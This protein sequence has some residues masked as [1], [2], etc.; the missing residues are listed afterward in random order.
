MARYFLRFRHSDTGLT[1]TYNFFKKASDLSVVTP[2]A[3]GEVG[4]GTYY[5]DYSPTFDIVF[6]VDGGVSIP[7]EE[8]RYIADT[9]SPKDVFVDEPTSQVKDDVWNDVVN[10]T[11]GTKG[12]YVEKI[13]GIETATTAAVIA[14]DVWDAQLA[15]HAVAGS[16]GLTKQVLNLG[17]SGGAPFGNVI[18]L[19]GSASTENDFYNNAVIFIT[20]GTAVNQ[21]RRIVS[22]A[23][24]T[25]TAT[26]DRDWTGAFVPSFGDTYLIFA[27]NQ[28]N[29]GNVWDETA[30]THNAFDT[31]GQVLN[32]AKNTTDTIS[33]NTAPP[34]I[35][36][37]VWDAATAAHTTPLTF[38]AGGTAPSATVVAAAVWDEQTNL[39]VALGSYG[40]TLQ[41]LATGTAQDGAAG[42]IQLAVGS[43][44]ILDFYKGALIVLTDFTGAGQARTIVSYDEANV[45]AYVDRN[46]GTIPVGDNTQYMIVPQSA[47]PSAAAPSAAANAAAVWNET[48]AGH[49]TADSAGVAMKNS[50]KILKNRTKINTSLNTLTIYDDNG[51]SV[52]YVFN[53]KDAVGAPTGTSPFER[54]P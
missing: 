19:D 9:I 20:T 10:R 42:W 33:L 41:Q 29:A 26:V 22:Y 27:T 11:P 45:R 25:Q 47:L 44:A 16:F 31:T 50:F 8:V 30:S 24:A 37:A 51:T 34:A 5:F 18:I 43:S 2:P 14:A 53:L 52:L 32:A 12:D 28:L 3:I 48:L 4:S 36:N 49:V 13:P 6:E 17:V 15:A 38:G 7:T 40:Q 54:A 46:W 39:H 21:V 23:G 1:P 35:E